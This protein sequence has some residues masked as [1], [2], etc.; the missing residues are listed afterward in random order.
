MSAQPSLPFPRSL[1]QNKPERMAWVVLLSAFS[2]FVILAVSIPWTANYLLHHATSPM[3][4]QLKPTVGTILLYTAAGAEP[5]AVTNARD[6][7]LQGSKLVTTGEATQGVLALASGT[8][9]EQSIGAVHLYPGTDVTLL[10][11][12]Q[13]RFQRSREPYDVRLRLTE[14]RIRVFTNSRDKRALVVRVELPNGYAVLSEGSYNFSVQEGRTELSVSLGEARLFHRS[15][16]EL[17]VGPGLRTWMDSEQPPTEAISAERNLILA[18]DFGSSLSENWEVYSEA[19]YVAAG[20][21]ELGE[22]DGRRVA[23]FVRLGEDGVHTEVGIRQEIDQDVNSYDSMV[24]RLDV[25]LLRQ[26]LRGAGEKSSE[27][28]LRVEIAYTDIYG[29][30]LTWG[31]GFYYR[32]PPQEWSVSGG[33]KITPFTWYFYES[34]NLIELLRDTRPA[35][36][37]SVRLYASGWNYEAMISE[38][39]LFVE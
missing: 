18:G 37:N 39:G 9:S 19:P 34:P 6:D 35:R 10:R 7:V 8:N 16:A 32:D 2:V 23:H 4:A 27:F 5:I 11:L 15:N 33:E 13:P 3:V 17:V 24:F 21:V 1:W 26:T 22:Q 20:S 36:I 25:R 30:D 38:V 12:Q 28:P 29:K 14:G 31:H